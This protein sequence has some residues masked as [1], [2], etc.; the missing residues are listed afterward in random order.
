MSLSPA[1]LSYVAAVVDNYAKLTTRVVH[2]DQ[3]PVVTIQGKL[4]VLHWLAE[5]TGVSLMT[6]DKD[7]VRHQCTEHC[8]DKHMPIVSWTYRWQ[9]TGARATVVLYNI[10]PFMRVQAREARDLV[11]LGRT[12]GFKTNVVNDMTRL[13]WHAPDLRKQPRARLEIQQ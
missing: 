10:E 7:Y 2:S 3:L 5:I 4:N 6:L 8:P 1:D 9:L 13:G 12:V 11:E